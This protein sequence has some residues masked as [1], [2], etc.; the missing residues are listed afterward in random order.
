MFEYAWTYIDHE[1]ENKDRYDIHIFKTVH[2]SYLRVNVY[3]DVVYTFPLDC[4][5]SGCFCS[6]FGWGVR[7]PKRSI[8]KIVTET[9]SRLYR[10]LLVR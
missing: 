5:F 2:K 8:R 10:V 6:E 9:M 3:I 4:L 7:S 1:P